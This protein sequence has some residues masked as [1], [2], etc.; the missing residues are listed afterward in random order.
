MEDK[1]YKVSQAHT[2]Y[3]TADG[4]RVPGVTTVLGV[5]NKPALIK[6]ANDKAG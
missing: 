1:L 4:I 5:L 6:W 3:K 2:V